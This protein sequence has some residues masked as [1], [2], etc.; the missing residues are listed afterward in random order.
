M[1]LLTK[2]QILSASDRPYEDVNIPEWGGTVRVR[3]WGGWERDRWDALKTNGT[4]PDDARAAIA[5]FSLVDEQG[6]RMFTD[7]DVKR[8]SEKSGLALD[9]VL[10]AVFRLNGIGQD[11]LE[12]AKKN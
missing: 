4:T 12:D 11:E 6:N 5:A 9:K 1:S 2:E 7:A 3:L 10:A 8:L